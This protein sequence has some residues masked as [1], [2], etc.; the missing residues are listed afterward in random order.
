MPL[1]Q[2]DHALETLLSDR[3]NEPFGVR[4]KIGTLWRQSDG[5]DPTTGQ[6]LPKATGIQGIAVVNQMAGCP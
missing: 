3:P 5:L 1:A 2:R 6:D 4:V